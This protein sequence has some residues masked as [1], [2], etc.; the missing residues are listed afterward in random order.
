MEW[1][2]LLPCILFGLVLYVLRRPSFH[3]VLHNSYA[4]TIKKDFIVSWKATF[5]A[6]KSFQFRAIEARFIPRGKLLF[7]V[8]SVPSTCRTC[9]I[10]LKCENWRPSSKILLTG[11]KPAITTRSNKLLLPWLYN[12]PNN[13]L[14]GFRQALYVATRLNRT[15]VMPIFMKHFTDSK[16]QE[17]DP[18][19][20]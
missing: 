9:N 17:I 5:F 8:P 4:V 7:P 3:D 19:H 18:N 2:R 10:T 20:R 12:G 13:Q 6:G 16:D 14:Y 15:L 1:Q 11:G